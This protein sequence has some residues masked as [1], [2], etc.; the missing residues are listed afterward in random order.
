MFKTSIF[1]PGKQVFDD[2]YASKVVKKRFIINLAN[3]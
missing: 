1:R 3:I 2:G